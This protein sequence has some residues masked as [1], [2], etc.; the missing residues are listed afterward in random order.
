MEILVKG[1]SFETKVLQ[2]L[3]I[4]I[5][6]HPREAQAFRA[7]IKD[8]RKR[9]KRASGMESGEDGQG[10]F[11]YGGIPEFVKRLL[12]MSEFS[13]Q[14]MYGKPCGTGDPVWHTRP[15]L[16]EAFFRVCSD[17][18]LSSLTSVPRTGRE[19]E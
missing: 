7:A 19:E 11:V 18:K 5:T 3:D 16:Y 4:Y 12:S 9:L 17:G 13:A 2:A 6:Q 10:I 15:G 8:D 1:A 14:M